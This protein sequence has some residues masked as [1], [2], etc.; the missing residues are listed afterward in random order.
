MKQQAEAMDPAGRSAPGRPTTAMRKAQAVAL[1]RSGMS[2]RNAAKAMGCSEQWF[3]E[4]LRM[5]GEP[6]R[7]QRVKAP[8]MAE[9]VREHAVQIM[10]RYDSGEPIYKIAADLQLNHHFVADFLYGRTLGLNDSDPLLVPYQPRKNGKAAKAAKAARA[11]TPKQAEAVALY[12]TGIELPWIQM[13]ISRAAFYSLITRAGEP[14]TRERTRARRTSKHEARIREHA[15]EIF[16][17]YDERKSVGFIAKSIGV[18]RDLLS[19]FL[20]AHG[21]E[22]RFRKT[23]QAERDRWIALYTRS[24]M[25]A[26]E[27]A[28]R[29]GR[30]LRTITDSLRDEG[31]LRTIAEATLLKKQQQRARRKGRKMNR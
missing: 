20:R 8:V 30:P 9:R 7:A 16:R 13:K 31:V 23:S 4:L 3:Y 5:A 1:Y 10:D 21:Y 26:P 27:I 6:T 14:R 2:G 28:R 25:S 19:E 12:R 24:M 15:N 17:A 11:V 18:P 22:P 29:T